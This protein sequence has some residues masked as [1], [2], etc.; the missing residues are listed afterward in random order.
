L[1]RKKKHV[2]NLEIE[3]DFAVIGLSSHQK[4]FKLSWSINK[5]LHWQ[6]KK[7]DDV[8][9]ELKS[10]TAKVPF[11]LFSFVNNELGCEFLM[12]ENKHQGYQLL[13]EVKGADYLIIVRGAY[14]KELL[15]E[16]I[17][18]LK[19]NSLINT[20]FEVDENKIVNKQNLYF[21]L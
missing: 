4:D 3:I 7:E 10:S 12:L 2:L 16:T 20:A 9:V 6:L 21:L 1:A 13:P 19:Q 17:E 14:S 8:L 18:K 11:T 5:H 15:T